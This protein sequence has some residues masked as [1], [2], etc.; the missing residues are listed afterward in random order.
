MTVTRERLVTWLRRNAEVLE[1]DQDTWPDDFDLDN[2]AYLLNRT[3]NI[4]EIYCPDDL[5]TIYNHNP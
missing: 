1:T 4:V 5:S 3:A 2:L